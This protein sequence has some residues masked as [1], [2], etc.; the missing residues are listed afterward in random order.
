[1]AGTVLKTRILLT[2]AGLGLL[3]GAAAQAGVV[4]SESRQNPPEFFAN[5]ANPRPEAFA[6]S[7]S[8]YCGISGIDVT[9]QVAVEE[10]ALITAAHFF[11][12][13]ATTRLRSGL[14]GCFWTPL[15][16]VLA[17]QR[18]KLRIDTL[19][20]FA[21]DAT[22]AG[23]RFEYP[24]DLQQDL[25]MVRLEFPRNIVL[26]TAPYALDAQFSIN[27]ESG[28]FMFSAVDGGTKTNHDYSPALQTCSTRDFDTVW[29]F[30]GNLPMLYTD[31]DVEN[32]GP[33]GAALLRRNGDHLVI[34][35]ILSGY[36][37][38]VQNRM[39]YLG[40]YSKLENSAVFIGISAKAQKWIANYI[41]TIH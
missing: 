18:I 31:C 13:P 5:A 4:D 15:F 6:G 22:G 19:R 30:S 35:G 34:R 2:L 17:G 9:A 25:A 37:G 3:F 38:I 41:S 12:D 36:Y 40:P 20:I 26:R 14:E 28:F 24:R 39:P 7:G 33:S 32:P 11:F 8:L 27:P 1:M 23:L 29:S 16:G 10:D 21:S